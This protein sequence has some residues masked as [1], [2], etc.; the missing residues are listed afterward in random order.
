MANNYKNVIWWSGGVSSAIAAHLFL[1]NNEATIIF[2]QTGSEHLDT[3]RFLK[4]CEKWYGQKIEILRSNLYQD[5]F[6]CLEKN[7]YIKMVNVGKLAPVI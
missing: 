5:H 4:D 6:D 2:L 3:F 1:K 7:K